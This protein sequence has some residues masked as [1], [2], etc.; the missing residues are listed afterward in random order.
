L[1]FEVCVTETFKGA[2]V[3]DVSTRGICCCPVSVDE[4]CWDFEVREEDSCSA[5]TGS[6]ESELADKRDTSSYDENIS[7][8]EYFEVF[9]SS[10]HIG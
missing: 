3:C 10:R 5:S 8:G 9:S 6:Y 7:F 4:D 2:G 1:I